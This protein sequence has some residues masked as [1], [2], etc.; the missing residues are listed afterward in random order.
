MKSIRAGQERRMEKRYTINEAVTLLLGH[1]GIFKAKTRDISHSGTFIEWQPSTAMMT[2][3]LS[4][5]ERIGVCFT[6]RHHRRRLIRTLEARVVRISGE[7]IGL[8]F[9]SQDRG[10]L[11]ALGVH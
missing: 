3:D 7:G 6:L 10:I 2:K 8:R 4:V 11:R 9:L 5:A 1:S